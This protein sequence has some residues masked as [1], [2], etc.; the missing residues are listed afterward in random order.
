M[1]ESPSPALPN[2]NPGCPALPSDLLGMK[3]LEKMSGLGLSYAQGS[4]SQRVAFP[5]SVWDGNKNHPWFQV[6]LPGPRPGKDSAW[7][8]GSFPAQGEAG[9]RTGNCQGCF[10]LSPGFH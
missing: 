3:Q 10:V 2:P 1:P 6:L 4:G 7:S 5:A 9:Y 8:S